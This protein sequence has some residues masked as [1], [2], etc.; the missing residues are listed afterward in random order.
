MSPVIIAIDGPA[1]SGK[2]STARSVAAGLGFRHLDSGALYR[3]VTLAAVRAGLPRPFDAA[4]VVA[5]AE[6]WGVDLRPRNGDFEVVAVEPV[7]DASLR[8]AVVTE[9]VS[10]IAALAGVRGWVNEHL[11]RAARMGQA[12]VV[13]GRDIGSVVFPEAQLK[14]YLTASPETRAGRRLRQRGEAVDPEQLRGET[15]ALAVRDQ[16]D[17]TRAEAPLVQAADAVALDTSDL[18]FEE[19]VARIM[20]LAQD[21]GLALHG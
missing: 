20:A 8:A 14:V 7:P 19:Q 12:V 10:E 1:A 9:H 3:G 21:R 13:D 6:R 11:R 2:S 15:E 17:S 4:D 16:A 5:E 18:S